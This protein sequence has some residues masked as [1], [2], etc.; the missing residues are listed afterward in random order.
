MKLR[1]VESVVELARSNIKM[2]KNILIGLLVL[3][4]GL[5]LVGCDEIVDEIAKSYFGFNNYSSQAVTVSVAG[6]GSSFTLAPNQSQ[7]VYLAENVTINDIIY[8]PANLVS[9]S[10]TGNAFYFRDR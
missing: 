7:N 10:R 8:S 2:K 3:A 5:F 1:N 9:V 6:G 4:I